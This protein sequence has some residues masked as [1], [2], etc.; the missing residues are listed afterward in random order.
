MSALVQAVAQLAMLLHLTALGHAP[1]TAAAEAVSILI[2]E[3]APVL[4]LLM[5]GY[6]AEEMAIAPAVLV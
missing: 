1:V 5:P 6:P 3:L 2:Q 4:Y